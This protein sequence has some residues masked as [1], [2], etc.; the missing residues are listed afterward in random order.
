PHR[1]GQRPRRGRGR[2][3][4][5]ILDGY[6][7][8][9]PRT[10]GPRRDDHRGTGAASNDG[11]NSTRLTDHGNA[12]DLTSPRP[13]DALDHS[14]TRRN[15]RRTWTNTARSGSPARSPVTSLPSRQLASPSGSWAVWVHHRS[16]AGRSL[17]RR[18][19]SSDSNRTN[20]MNRPSSVTPPVNPSQPV[21]PVA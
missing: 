9:W 15:A 13:N 5:L 20:A 7:Q 19:A 8:R 3:T 1:P 2:D 18:A 21:A 16:C 12:V 11:E 4:E 14:V 10:K 6:G 17:L